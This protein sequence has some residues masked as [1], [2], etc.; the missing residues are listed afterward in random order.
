M[1]GGVILERE[2]LS[3]RLG[4]ILL[5]A[6]CAIGLGNVWRFPFIT[7][8]YG[9]A[10][11][12]LI[13]LA[14]LVLMGLPIMV[15]EF[16]VGRAS[17]KSAGKSMDVLEPKGTSWHLY[18]WAALIGCTTLMMFYTTVS[19]WILNYFWKMLK[20]DF[21]GLTPD[22]IGAAFGGMVS[23]PTV[24]IVCMII[25]TIVG[26]GVCYFGV[27]KGVERVTKPMMLCLFFLIVALAIRSC[28]LDGALE[29]LRYYLLPNFDRLFQAGIGEVIFAA[30]GQAFF[31]L[32]LGVGA[33]AIFGSY[34]GKDRSFTGEAI[35]VI[36]LDTFIAL[37][38]GL[39]I[40]PACSAFGVNQAA[41]PVLLFITLPN[42]FT[43]M[44]NGQ[45]WGALFFMFMLFAALSTVI[46]VF[47]NIIAICIDMFDTDRKSIIKTLCPLLI[48]LSL[49]CIFGFNIW[50]GF[51]PM[52]KGSCVL[53]LEDFIVSNNIL[54]LGSLLYLLFCTQKK[55]WGWDNFIKEANDGKGLLFPE[56]A[57]AYLTYILPLLILAIYIQGYISIFF[58]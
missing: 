27:Q 31:T 17:K 40:F 30:M 21:V 22:Q 42:V 1:K 52:G 58:K 3:S 35:W 49:P 12:V 33:L 32:S 29:G 19:G 51:Q 8:A 2:S 47:E 11:F 26:F 56:S 18:K 43:A 4:F 44:G 24:Q 25:I 46:A 10:A 5:S 45:F 48:V 14:F 34:I 36:C 54:P 23:D 16:S 57:K 39:I 13:Y 7:G 38:A 6:G 50:S 28:T 53:D 20:G 37:M 55:G 41:G 15:M 9:G